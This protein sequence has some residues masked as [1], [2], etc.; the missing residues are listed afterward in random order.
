MP[1]YG[2]FVLSADKIESQFTANYL[3]HFLSTNLLLKEG[4]VSFSEGN[5]GYQMADIEIDNFNFK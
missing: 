4:A 5:F 3:G 2:Q 1:G